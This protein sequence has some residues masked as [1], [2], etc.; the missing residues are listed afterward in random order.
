MLFG[1][2]G[3]NGPDTS[4]RQSRCNY[5]QFPREYTVLEQVVASWQ[6]SVSNSHLDERTLD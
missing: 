5:R 3:V 2:K 1:V 6:Q 4:H